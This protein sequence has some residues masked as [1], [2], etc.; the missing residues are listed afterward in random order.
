MDTTVLNLDGV[1]ASG[2]V[3]RL[4]KARKLHCPRCFCLPETGLRNPHGVVVSLEV[5]RGLA[6]DIRRALDDDRLV[7]F[8]GVVVLGLE[9]KRL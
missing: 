7:L 8:A 2:H 3:E 6:L 5:D 9:F 4:L 1:T